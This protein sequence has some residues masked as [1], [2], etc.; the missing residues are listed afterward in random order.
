MQ[1]MKR[2]YSSF[3]LLSL[4][5]SFPACGKRPKNFFSF[6][7]K[8]QK[9]VLERSMFPSI[10]N[11]FYKKIRDSSL[12]WWNHLQSQNLVGYNIYRF[13]AQGFIPKKPLNKEPLIKP[14]FLDLDVIVNVIPYYI[15][16]GVFLVD[17]KMQE[18][19]SSP[20]LVAS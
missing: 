3:G 5:I 4:I 20:I 8:V 18:G 7:E 19:P 17:G 11:L 13:S 12:V 6:E 16:R 15:V 9:E 10:K 1:P 14:E 2:L